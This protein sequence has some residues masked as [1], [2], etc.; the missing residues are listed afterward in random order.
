MLKHFGQG[1]MTLADFS[2]CGGSLRLR[3]PQIAGKPLLPRL[4]FALKN[5]VSRAKIRFN[6][7]MKHAEACT[8]KLYIKNAP[9]FLKNPCKALKNRVSLPTLRA[10]ARFSVRHAPRKS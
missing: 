4:F 10:W 7:M 6:G 3:P 9:V 5:P 2:I 8:S 1:R